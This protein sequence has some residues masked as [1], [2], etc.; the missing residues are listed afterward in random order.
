MIEANVVHAAWEFGVKKLLF[1][2]SSCIYPKFASQPINEESLL[3]GVL[4]PTNEPYAIAK[5]AGIKLCESYSRQY[6]VDFRSVMPTNLYGPGDNYHPLNSHVIPGLIQ[7]FHQAKHKNLTKV[8]VWGTGKPRREFLYVDDTVNAIIDAIH[9]DKSGPFNLGT[10]QETSVKD[11]V[12]TISNL[13]RFKGNIVWDASK[14]NGQPR[15]FYDMSKFKEAFGYVPN[16]SLIEGL[17][18]TIEW[19]ES[20]K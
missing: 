10:G 15:R 8:E 4:E 13:V 17:K 5:I 20:N 9:V 7:K 19:Y 6:G 3:T 1:I 2:G 11:L 14:P 16:T 18:K 12:E